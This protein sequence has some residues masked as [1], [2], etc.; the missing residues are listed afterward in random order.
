L[1]RRPAEK[2]ERCLRVA[3]YLASF[4]IYDILDRSISF[5]K[6]YEPDRLLRTSYSSC[7]VLITVAPGSGASIGATILQRFI[8]G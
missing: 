4:K 3:Q 1:R 7:A 5:P 6:T 2:C 8:E